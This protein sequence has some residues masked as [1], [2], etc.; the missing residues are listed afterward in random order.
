M[1]KHW[2]I[3]WVLCLAGGGW[4]I[5]ID[6]RY[7]WNQLSTWQWTLSAVSYIALVVGVLLI[8]SWLPRRKLK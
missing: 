2:L 6:V 1:T 5:Y 7:G 3:G 4:I 8:P